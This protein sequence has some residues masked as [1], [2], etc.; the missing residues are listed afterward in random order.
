MKTAGI[1]GRLAVL[2]D[3]GHADAGSRRRPRPRR[4][5]ALA[6]S[7]GVHGRYGDIDGVWTE[8][9]TAQVMMT[10]FDLHGSASAAHRQIEFVGQ[11]SERA[12]E[13]LDD[14]ADLCRR[15]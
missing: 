8:P 11:L 15:W 4:W 6:I 14:L 9:V 12:V 13:N 7:S 10:F 2:R 3:R 5:I 1:G